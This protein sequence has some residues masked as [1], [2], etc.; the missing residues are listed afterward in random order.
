[1]LKKMEGERRERTV[2]RIYL[3]YLDQFSASTLLFQGVRREK[4]IR[5]T[6]VREFRIF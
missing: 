2:E 4:R 1:M 6:R 3:S 5:S